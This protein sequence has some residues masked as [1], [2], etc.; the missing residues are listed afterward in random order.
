MLNSLK[1][2]IIMYYQLIL[3]I[4]FR[5]QHSNINK[6]INCNIYKLNFKLKII[7]IIDGLYHLDI[8]WTF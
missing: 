5:K 4:R 1:I 3:R 8:S 6:Q 2:L 7:V